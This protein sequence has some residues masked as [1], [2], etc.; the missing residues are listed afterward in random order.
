MWG[1]RF[2]SSSGVRM[3]GS[4]EEVLVEALTSTTGGTMTGLVGS[5]EEELV[6]ALAAAAGCTMVELVGSEDEL[7]AEALAAT[8]GCTST[9]LVSVLAPVPVG[10]WATSG[11]S[12]GEGLPAWEAVPSGAPVGAW[13]ASG[14]WLG[15]GLPAWEAGA[16]LGDCCCCCCCWVEGAGEVTMVLPVLP[17][18][19]PSPAG[20]PSTPLVPAV[21]AA[22]KGLGDV[23]M[24]SG[25]GSGGDCASPALHGPSLTKRSASGKPHPHK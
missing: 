22:L 3:V 25:D 6:E 24:A 13:A 18:S 15:E 2:A 10:V 7:L 1:R 19:G 16:A 17:L 12:L 20:A 21:P 9:G 8:A 11:D 4:E 14:D 23:V 5:E